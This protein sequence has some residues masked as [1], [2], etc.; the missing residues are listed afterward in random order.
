MKI[1]RK[2]H[3]FLFRWHR[4]ALR[5]PKATLLITLLLIALSLAGVLRYRFLLSIDDLIDPDFGSYH[6]LETVKKN[7][8]DYNSIIIS[9][10]PSSM[11]SKA[12]LCDIEAWAV[13]LDEKRQDILRIS[14]SFGVRQAELD[15]K[16]LKFKSV[17]DLDCLNASDEPEKVLLGFEKLKKSPW[18][19]LLTNNQN[20]IT[21]VI[22]FLGEG[23][24]GRFGEFRSETVKE[25]R[26]DFEQSLK[27]WTDKFKVY[28]GGVGTYQYELR[29]SFYT[30][31][32]L[33]MVMFAV[34]LLFFKLFFGSWGAGW[35]YIITVDITLTLVYGFMGFLKIPVDVLTNT[36]GMILMV[37]ALEDLVFV[38]YGTVFLGM[39]WK[40]SMRYFLIPAFYTS[41]TTAV[42]FGSLVTSDL[43]IIRRFGLVSMAAGLV[44]WCFVFIV[45]PAALK[46]FKGKG[47]PLP[48][49]TVKNKVLSLLT[50]IPNFSISKR[51]SLFLLLAFPLGI[52]GAFFLNIQ[53]SPEK[54]FS[55]THIVTQVSDHFFNTRNWRSDISLLLNSNLSINEKNNILEKARNWPNI[56]VVEDLYS[57]EDYLVKKIEK[58][59]QK[60]AVLKIW[61]SSPFALRLKHEDQERAILYVKSL[62]RSDLEKLIA[63][64]NKD[65]PNQECELGSGLTSYVEFGER[66]LKTLFESLFISIVL[67]ISII[68]GLCLYFR[69][70]HTLA[71]IV[72]S[73]WG[74][75]ALLVTFYVFQ[76]PVFFV[77]TICAAVL[78][79]LSGDNS[80]QFIFHER[81]RD[82]ASSVH[83]LAPA[84]FL[85]TI[86]MILLTTIFF[87]S[88]MWPLQ[89]LGGLMMIGFLMSWIGDVLVLKGLTKK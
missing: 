4:I 17:F 85:V 40:K 83:T 63:A 56:S 73:I 27:P 78:V 86:G 88:P 57:T 48:N 87:F 13:R 74:P 20:V 62:E 1:M 89:R 33:N 55:K 66:V 6:A 29:K 25:I 15:N 45:L 9:I 69:S 51:V 59:D 58:P 2:F 38:I 50:K 30:S 43:S 47:W 3:L 71:L 68:W 34:A 76:V 54:F 10:E 22:S 80:I 23:K 35:W 24:N 70:K 60:E 36:T 81:K 26:D 82:L 32:V 21:V 49:Q 31:Q 11:P 16:L 18:N 52:Y 44:E 64:V 39:T 79:G 53:D 67:V 61:R 46:I 75:F 14:S 41:L 12:L 72:S 37:S 65:C 77:T 7:F 42:G 5:N 19:N 8:P 84:A 28:W